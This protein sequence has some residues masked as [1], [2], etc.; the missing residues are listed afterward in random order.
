MMDGDYFRKQAAEVRGRADLASDT[1]IKNEL[2]KLAIEYH[3]LAE[4]A[5]ELHSVPASSPI[6]NT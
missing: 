6:S 3:R 4:Q 5:D 2:L 1:T